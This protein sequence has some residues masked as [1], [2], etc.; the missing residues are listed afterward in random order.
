M[1]QSIRTNGFLT[2]LGPINQTGTI[3][4]DWGREIIFFS[5]YYCCIKHLVFDKLGSFGSLHYHKQKD[6]YW[7][8]LRGSFMVITIDEHNNI[9]YEKLLKNSSIFI[10]KLVK[11]Q[12]YTL[13]DDSAI[14]ELSSADYKND[15]YRIL[16]SKVLFSHIGLK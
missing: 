2:N 1:V 7:I 9:N 6:E 13:E 3:E 12:L 4:K 11:H 14:L 5:N 15:T 16:R 10:P 8:G